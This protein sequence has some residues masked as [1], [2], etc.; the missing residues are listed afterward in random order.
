MSQS[1]GGG[2][3][4]ARTGHC[5]PAGTAEAVPTPRLS[6]RPDPYPADD[7]TI[8]WSDDRSGQALVM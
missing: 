5:P 1:I 3:A 6:G 7:Q 4:K 2:P 8:G